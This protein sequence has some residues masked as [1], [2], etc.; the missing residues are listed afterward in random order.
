MICGDRRISLG[1]IAPVVTR[2]HLHGP[3]L[4]N[5]SLSR[6][7][8]QE[9]RSNSSKGVIHSCCIFSCLYNVPVRYDKR[10]RGVEDGVHFSYVGNVLVVSS[11][12][13]VKSMLPC[14]SFDPYRQ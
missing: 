5:V 2:F 4:L 3:C 14:R 9:G 6:V 10:R 7:P 8:V 13:P 11:I 1:Q 12:L